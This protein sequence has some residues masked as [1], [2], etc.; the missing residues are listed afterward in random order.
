MKKMFL[1]FNLPVT[2]FK[3]NKRYVAYTP[4][5]DLSTSGRTYN[6]VKKRFGEIVNI[7]IEE[8]VRNNTLDQVLK[9]MGWTEVRKN[10]QPPTV[11]SHE[12]ETVKIAV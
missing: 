9:D 3:E 10:W 5:L 7:F 2:I 12:T 11:V 6:E 4:V 8:L 1:Q